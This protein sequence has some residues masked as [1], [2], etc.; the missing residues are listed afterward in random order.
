MKFRAEHAREF[1]NKGQAMAASCACVLL[2]FVVP[3]YNRVRDSL[4]RIVA[5]QI[6]SDPLETNLD[7]C[8]VSGEAR[9]PQPKTASKREV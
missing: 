4:D 7:L 8:R 2:G 9:A 5:G 6:L 1:S 3:L